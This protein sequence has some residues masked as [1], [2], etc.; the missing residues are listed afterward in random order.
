[1]DFTDDVLDALLLDGKVPAPLEQQPKETPLAYA[2]FLAYVTLGRKRSIRAVA[3]EHGHDERQAERW[4]HK[5]QWAKRVA[6]F[7]R[8]RLRAQ[9]LTILH[10]AYSKAEA[11]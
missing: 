3:Q 10:A 11:A 7:E 6:L 9:L 5:H 1:L 8:L 2:A 4:S